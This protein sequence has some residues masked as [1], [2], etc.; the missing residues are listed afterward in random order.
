M[1]CNQSRPVFELVSPCPFPTTI[2]IIPRASPLMVMTVY[3]GF[4]HY[5]LVWFPYS[6]VVFLMIL[7]LRVLEYFEAVFPL[8]RVLVVSIVFL[9]NLLLYR[10]GFWEKFV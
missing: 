9:E 2:T 1:K 10:W 6:K 3:A 5:V 7:I 8:G 4:C